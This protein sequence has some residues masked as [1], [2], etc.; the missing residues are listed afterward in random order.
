MKRN[1]KSS[2]QEKVL[3]CVDLVKRLGEK[4]GDD[5]AENERLGTLST[6]SPRG[7]DSLC[8]DPIDLA[9]SRLESIW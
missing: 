6:G 9:A 4:I 5:A 8:T 3:D 7:R 2:A 1:R